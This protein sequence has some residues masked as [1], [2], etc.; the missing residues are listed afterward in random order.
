MVLPKI[1]PEIKHFPG[2]L[3]NKVYDPWYLLFDLFGHYTLDDIRELLWDMYKAA[4]KDDTIYDLR[5]QRSDLVFFYERLNDLATAAYVVTRK[6][7]VKS[8]QYHL[9]KGD[10]KSV[11]I[12]KKRIK[13]FEAAQKRL[14]NDV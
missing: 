10:G 1:E 6:K 2:F 4:M 11:K 14:K 5:K 13:E 12:F 9:G 7:W 8:S 3:L